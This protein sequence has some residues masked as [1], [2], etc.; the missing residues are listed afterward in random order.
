MAL[1]TKYITLDEFEEYFNISLR[2]ALG[3]EGNAIAFLKRIE[4]RMETFIDANFCKSI[5]IYYPSFTDYQKAHYKRALLE[6]AIYVFRNGDVS[7]DSGYDT[8]KG[9]IADIN[10]IKKI[11][12]SPNAKQ[13]LILCGLWNRH[14]RG[15][16]GFGMPNGWWL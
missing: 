15:V 7:V 9:V 4:D 14:L 6:Q 5:E 13:E 2:G 16:R 12:I 1:Q 3:N 10:T 11:S 8:D